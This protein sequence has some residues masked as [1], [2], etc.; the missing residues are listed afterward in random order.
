MR[1]RI[2]GNRAQHTNRS[3]TDSGGIQ[4]RPVRGHYARLIALFVTHAGNRD[5]RNR[6]TPVVD[7]RGEIANS[8]HATMIVVAD[9]PAPPVSASAFDRYIAPGVHLPA[10]PPTH[11][12]RVSK[13]FATPTLCACRHC[14]GVS[15]ALSG[16]VSGCI[17]LG[18]SSTCA[19]LLASTW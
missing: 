9:S 13:P 11:C 2:K 5:A 3:V 12:T 8:V 16:R 1:A 19:P 14:S 18:R 15:S 10:L 4:P 7:R 17:R 6:V